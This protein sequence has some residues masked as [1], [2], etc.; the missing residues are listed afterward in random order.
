MTSLKH[1][2]TILAACA[3]LAG[4]AGAQYSANF[5]NPPYVLG[6]LEG[7]GIWTDWTG[8]NQTITQVVNTHNST[9]GGSQ[10]IRVSNG[11]DTVADFDLLPGGSFD[12]GQWTLTIQSFVP[13]GSTGTTYFLVMNQWDASGTPA[14]EWN[15]QL[16]LA[17]S[18]GRARLSTPDGLKET[19]LVTNAWVPIRCEYDLGAN[20]VSVY[21]NNVFLH[22][23]DPRCGVTNGC[24]GPYSG[25]FIDALDLY[26]DPGTLPSPIF[27]DDLSITGGSGG[28]PGTKYCFGDGSGTPCPCGNN[29]A[30]GGG[31][32]NST[33]NG[34]VLE[35]SGTSTVS[36]HDLVLTATSVRPSQPGLFFQAL[37]APNGGN[38]VVFGDGLR[39]AGGGVIR[40]GVGFASASGCIATDNSCG[41][42]NGGPIDIATK[43]GVSP[44]DLRRYQYWYR[45]PGTGSPCGATFNLSN[46]YTVL[47]N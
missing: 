25:S 20:V 18:I 43:G 2:I 36:A 46:G 22:T 14:Y 31:C 10:A 30:A 34:G 6:P 28:P 24:S 7:Q 37:N 3:G 4:L 44:G 8:V 23:Y 19:A 29:G 17:A 42:I 47:W 32:A 35:G 41:N 12:A 40:L 45:D 38:G 15:V 26:P 39:C 21:Y 16:A 27:F 33:G 13:A 11:A 1:P 9:P 5:E